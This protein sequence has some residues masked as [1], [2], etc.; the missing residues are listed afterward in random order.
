M[1]SLLSFLGFLF[2]H[3]KRHHQPSAVPQAREP[4]HSDVTGDEI[5]GSLKKTQNP[6]GPLFG[7]SHKLLGDRSDSE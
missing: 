2:I 5:T 3:A 1:L 4:Q 6:V 7:L